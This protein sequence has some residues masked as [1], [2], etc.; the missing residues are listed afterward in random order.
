MQFVKYNKNTILP[1]I[2]WTGSKR[3]LAPLLHQLMPR[4][5]TYIEPFIGSG[6]MLPYLKKYNIIA[7]DI[8]GPLIDFWDI[9]KYKPDI[10]IKHYKEEWNYLQQSLG[11]INSD[12]YASHFYYIRNRFNE[13]YCP[14]DLQF[15]T[16]T[17]VNG[18]VRFNNKGEFNCSF[19]LSRKGMHPNKYEYL[20]RIWNHY[21]KNVSFYCKDYR[22]ILKNIEDDSFIYLDPPYTNSKELYIHNIDSI[23]LFEQ[24]DYLN[25]NNIKWMLSYNTIREG[26]DYSSQAIVP[27]NLYKHQLVMPAFIS[28]MTNVLNNKPE[29]TNELVYVNYD[30]PE[31]PVQLSYF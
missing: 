10:A 23:E 7:S 11:D 25:N 31:R 13:Q 1:V 27:I 20:V 30:P 18:I 16:R 22:E 21:I 2:K 15:L 24:L 26:I 6:A 28:S 19:H 5:K 4:C 9:I 8:Y 3:H 14:L 17:C 29:Y 12:S